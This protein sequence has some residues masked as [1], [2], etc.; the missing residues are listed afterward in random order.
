MSSD[1]N[2]RRRKSKRKDESNVKS[3]KENEIDKKEKEDVSNE[4][5]ESIGRNVEIDLNRLRKIDKNLAIYIFSIHRE[6]LNLRNKLEQ[7]MVREREAIS[8]NIELS[9][10]LKAMRKENENLRATVSML[11]SRYEAKV[12]E[13]NYLRQEVEDLRLK[14]AIAESSFI[15]LSEAIEEMHDKISRHYLTD[16]AS[17]VRSDMEE[18]LSIMIENI[19]YLLSVFGIQTN[20]QSPPQVELPKQ[21]QTK[22]EVEK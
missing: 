18:N 15:S 6:L 7:S 2:K 21:K 9:A 5:K 11:T 3:K 19:R 22:I 20:L 8:K 1:E 13:A 12:R 16:I 10:E 17:K 14:M 4:I